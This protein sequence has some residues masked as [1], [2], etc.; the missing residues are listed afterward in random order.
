MDGRPAEN[1]GTVEGGVDM[2]GEMNASGENQP[3]VE[4]VDES[5]INQ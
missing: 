4:N 5:G 1:V 2:G 3:N